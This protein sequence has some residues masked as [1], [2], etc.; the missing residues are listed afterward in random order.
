MPKVSAISEAKT[1]LEAKDPHPLVLVTS[2]DRT[3][4]ERFTERYTKHFFNEESSREVYDCR[5]VSGDKI[6]LIASQ[7]DNLSLFSTHKILIFKYV[8]ALSAAEM[9]I[10]QECIDRR[11][12]DTSV[13]LLA[14]K[15][16][17][18]SVFLQYCR[19]HGAVIEFPELKGPELRRWIRKE[20]SLCGVS[21]IG[22]DAIEFLCALSEESLDALVHF[23]GIASLYVEN[24]KITIKDLHDLFKSVLH[25]NDFEIAD[26]VFDGRAS[27]ARLLLAQSLADGGNPYGVVS[28]VGRL[29]SQVAV[30]RFESD[31]GGGLAQVR[32]ALS[33]S[34]WQ[35][36]KIT[37]FSRKNTSDHLRER[38]KLLLKADSRLK[39]R[40]VHIADIL[41]GALCDIKR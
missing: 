15:I 37:N 1:I 36:N 3:R 18:K 39:N 2:I 40:S 6:K 29:C 19:K 34:P 5:D 17:E 9:K 28:I 30:A 41:D 8:D 38:L 4:R 20:S 14:E 7:T 24:G 26:M 33:V 12:I 31:T 35:F 16:P 32:E 27:K 11:G 25:S 23:I 21:E 10:L 13:L 22:D